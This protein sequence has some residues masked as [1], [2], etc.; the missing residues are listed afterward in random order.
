MS[1]SVSVYLS[2][3]YISGSSVARSIIKRNTL[4]LFAA[5]NN[6]KWECGLLLLLSSGLLGGLL[7]RNLLLKG[8]RVPLLAL[9]L[10]ESVLLRGGLAFPLGVSVRGPRPVHV[11]TVP[12]AH[13]TDQTC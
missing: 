2:I 1:F 12:P 8:L 5:S 7:R 3:I 4:G 13:R 9:G 6:H 11:P 10:R